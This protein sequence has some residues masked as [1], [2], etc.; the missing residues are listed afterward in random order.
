M[1]VT[2]FEQSLGVLG[3]RFTGH[4]RDTVPALF[5]LAEPFDQVLLAHPMTEAITV[6][7]RSRDDSESPYADR[8][9]PEV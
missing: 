2:V 4:V 1:E 6:P 7:V 9:G 5:R 3:P 8:D